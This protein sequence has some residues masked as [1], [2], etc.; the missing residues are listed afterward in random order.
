V[1]TFSGKS[2]TLPFLM[3]LLDHW[4]L[5]RLAAV[6]ART[7]PSVSKIPL[8]FKLVLEKL[9]F[10]ALSVGSSLITLAAQKDAMPSIDMVPFQARLFNALLS[11]T[12]YIAKMVWP[13]SLSVFY[14]L[15]LNIPLWLTTSSAAVFI[16]I[17]GLALRC[18]R[19]R[20][21]VFTGWFWYVGMLVPVIGLVQVG[22][23]AMAD[24]Y[25]YI[26]LT[27][28][29]I[30]VVWTISESK[31]PRGYGKRFMWPL[32]GSALLFFAFLT[33]RQTNLWAND[34]TLFSHAVKVNDNFMAHSLVG[35][36]FIKTGQI[37]DALKAL[38]T[39]IRIKPDDA[40]ALNYMGLALAHAQRFEEAEAYFAAAI[41]KNPKP[42]KALYN[43]G[44]IQSA[45]GDYR[46]A[47]QN[48]SLALQY[49][50]EDDEC[51]FLLAFSL[52]ETGRM[53]EAVAHYLNLLER[54]PD[55]PDI[56]NN[57][58]VAFAR[59]GQMLQAED[60]FNRAIAVNPMDAEALHNLQA[61]RASAPSSDFKGGKK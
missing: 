47:A 18:V 16:T 49:L 55:R 40:Q 45:K 44:F 10:M 1:S 31:I 43:L 53:E 34:L 39:A 30:I 23:Q 36:H 4:P 28:L 2:E 42:G 19:T 59:M 41:K 6:D 11:Y 35:A 21:Y 38:G 8:F 51:R 27:G 14:P 61:S 32:A 29:F 57:L 15:Q 25:T 3:L 48:F 26:P 17:T 33:F 20:P 52:S 22:G 12:D 58:G 50:P 37:E 9:P 7:P 5:N 13:E 54:N 56:H 46:S 60:H 24:R